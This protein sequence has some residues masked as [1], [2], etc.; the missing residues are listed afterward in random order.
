MN[1]DEIIKLYNKYNIKYEDNI[2]N[3]SNSLKENDKLSINEENEIVSDEDNN[4]KLTTV[5]ELSEVSNE[6]DEDKNNYYEYEKNENCRNFNISEYAKYDHKSNTNRNYEY[7]DKINQNVNLKE[8]KNRNLNNNDNN[9]V[10][11]NRQKSK[12]KSN[13]NENDQ[14]LINNA[15]KKNNLIQN[16]NNKNLNLNNN[17]NSNVMNSINSNNSKNFTPDIQEINSKL[18]VVKSNVELLKNSLLTDFEN[19]EKELNRMFSS[20]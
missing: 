14:Y 9:R 12:S 1:K 11:S 4:Y 3:L 2:E 10:N 17:V 6:K 8:Y 15:L 7:N 16:E 19:L 20:S 18:S 5:K 13:E